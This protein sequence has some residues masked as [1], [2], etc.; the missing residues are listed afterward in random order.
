MK[1]VKFR[2]KKDDMSDSSFC[3]GNLIYGMNGEPRIQFKNTMTFTT[4]LKGTEGQYT[5][6]KDNNG[7]EIYESDL[8]LTPSNKPEIV[9]LDKYS[10]SE[11][12]EVET[13]LGWNCGGNTLP[14][15]I[16]DGFIVI[17]NNHEN[18]ELLEK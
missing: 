4:C 5:G 16:K 12:Y 17:G 7:K 18:P 1:E 13:H 11:C 14:D 10:D 9:V 15:L 2:A 8:F 6:L 3:Y